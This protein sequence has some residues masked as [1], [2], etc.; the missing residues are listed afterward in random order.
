MPK[1]RNNSESMTVKAE[2]VGEVNNDWTKG[3]GLARPSEL[4]VDFNS[5][6][7]NLD[8]NDLE[9]FKEA[10]AT[11]P[12]WKSHITVSLKPGQCVRGTYLGQGPDLE[13]SPDPKTGEIKSVRTWIFQV[14]ARVTVML[15]GSHQIDSRL[16][17]FPI[18]DE[19]GIMHTGQTSS[20]SRRVNQYRFFTKHRAVSNSPQLA[21][22]AAAPT[23][24]GPAAPA[25]NGAA[26]SGQQS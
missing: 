19:M 7:A 21:A 24:N 10:I 22:P 18:G 11:D 3:E 4:G 15:L 23:A 6:V 25:A 13:L 1:V 16:Q 9:S 17:K 5:D 12:E 20:G 8:L 2:D 14:N 26:P